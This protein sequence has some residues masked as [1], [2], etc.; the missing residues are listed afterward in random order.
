MA[1]NV[2]SLS[3]TGEGKRGIRD[4]E[5][6][7][8]IRCVGR[9]EDSTYICNTHHISRYFV[10]IT[11]FFKEKKEA[12]T[13]LARTNDMESPS[14]TSSARLRGGERVYAREYE[15]FF[16]LFLPFVS[17]LVAGAITMEIYILLDDFKKKIEA[18]YAGWLAGPLNRGK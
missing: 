15:G 10:Y 8:K 7:R 6:R 17:I 11:Y 9:E 18:I 14:V 13:T 1:F 5:K 4:T 16:S 12:T 2:K 3:P